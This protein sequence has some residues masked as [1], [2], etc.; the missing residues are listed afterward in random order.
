MSGHSK[1]NNIK[2]KKEITDGAKAKVFTKMGRE[3]SIAVREGGADPSTNFKLYTLVAKAKA[4]NVPN[5]NIERAIKKAA[6]ADNKDEYEVIMY[7]GYGP[8]GVAFMVETMTDNRNRTAGDLRHFFDKTGGNL[9]QTGCVSFMFN[10]KG[11]IT[12]NA[13]DIDEEKLTEACI[14]AGAED[15]TLEDE[16]FVI[17]TATA[18]LETVGAA[19]Q[20][21]GYKL[22]SEETA[23]I[24]T[25]Y[26]KV[27][28]EEALI[29]LNRLTDALD[30]NDDVTDYWHSM[31]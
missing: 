12:V 20:K 14:D 1:W 17:T 8:A 31:E 23:Y 4:N 9:G 18:D 25:T 28:D 3:I 5:D 26:T 29:K 30:E 2:R 21:A 16:S 7:E 11:V 15:I 27:T 22:E 24:P 13:E 19:L 6:G 10:Q